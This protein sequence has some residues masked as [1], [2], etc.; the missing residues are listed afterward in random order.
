MA[1]S[2]SF[3]WMNGRLATGL[4]ARTDDISR[5]DDDGFWVVS[6]T[7]EGQAI[8]AKFEKIVDDQPFPAQPDWGPIQD[9]WR[10]SL[11]KV[12]F[13]SYVQE[14]RKQISLG[15]VYQVNACRILTTQCS[16]QSIAPLFAETL[17]HNPAQYAAFLR[18][19]DIEIASASPELFLRREGDA[20][21]T[22]PMKG[23]RAYETGSGFGEKDVSEN[24]MIV[25]LMR[26]DLGR[27]AT[28]GTVQATALFRE[29]DHPGLIQL[30][31]DVQANLRSEITWQE[32]FQNLLP[33][34]SVS[35]AP[36]IA[37]TTIIANNEPVDRENYCGTFG[38]IHGDQALLNVA[39]RTFWKRGS[40]LSY[41]T[42][43]GITWG[44]DPGS[45]WEETELKTANL[46]RIAGGFN[47]IGWPFDNGIFE[48]I[49]TEFGKPLLLA[50]HLARAER[51][52]KTLGM[53]F[54]EI[55]WIHSQVIEPHQKVLEKFAIGRLRLT[56][57]KQVGVYV[58]EYQ[59]SKNPLRICTVSVATLPGIGKH[60]T[61]PYTKNL[62]LLAQGT[63]RGFDEVLLVD[64]F[65]VIGEGAISNY[66]FLI[67][68]DWLTPHEDAGVLPGIVRALALENQLISEGQLT[69]EEVRKSKSVIALSSM[70]I[71]QPVV[72][73]DDEVFEVGAEVFELRSILRK[74][75]GSNSVG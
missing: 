11:S 35:G 48:T 28:I 4:L 9:R 69:F 70:K 14:I 64:P 74:I 2:T 7:F 58:E 16:A 49:R 15:N 68:G 57:G 17:K 21:L 63:S 62:K 38:W 41:G 53:T 31:S 50:E 10:S 24:L 23:T 19:P 67:D 26:N 72:Q 32:I 55:P 43:A 22:S 18:L 1:D 60:K 75:C 29:E 20:V 52:A 13:E 73:I 30:V 56:F 51:S 42:G 6:T 37:A 36:K 61:Y 44:S 40:V 3:F 47:E 33:P 54:P 25:D 27:I 12:D 71:A 65:G 34:G 8:C 39:I 5:L 66:A 59:E 45:E 46:L